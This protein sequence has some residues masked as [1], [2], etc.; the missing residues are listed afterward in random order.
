MHYEP[1]EVNLVGLPKI[2]APEPAA[3]IPADRGRGGARR[4]RRGP[5][6][7]GVRGAG[8]SGKAQR[9]KP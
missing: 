2:S 6:G 9:C 3:G 1:R 8:H 7:D 4:G 5:G